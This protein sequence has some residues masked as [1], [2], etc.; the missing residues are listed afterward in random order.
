MGV[1]EKESSRELRQNDKPIN[2]DWEEV[3]QKGK[4]KP[5]QEKKSL[6]SSENKPG[7]AT[8]TRWDAHWENFIDINP[9]RTARGWWDHLK[10]KRCFHS[11]KD[12]ASREK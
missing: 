10:G 4:I 12:T 5:D 11:G 7:V 6:G 1:E 3:N 8:K 2:L 9:D